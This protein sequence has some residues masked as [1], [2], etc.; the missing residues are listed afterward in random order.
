MSKSRILLVIGVGRSGTSAFVGIVRELGFYVPQPEVVA[1]DTNPRGFGEPRWV[2]DFHT[3]LLKKRAVTTIDSR[4]SAWETTATAATDD[5]VVA[6][7]RSWL[8]VQLVGADRIVVKDPRISWFLPLWRRCAEELGADTEFVTMLRPPTEVLASARQWYGT[9]QNDASRAGG[10]VNIMLRTERQSRGLPRAFV[11]YDDLLADWVAT[12]GRVG[13]LL[14]EP[15]LHDLDDSRRSRIDAFVSPELHRQIRGWED[16][17]VPTPLRG[18]VD[19]SWEALL[20]LAADGK[21][22]PTL[23]E[24]RREYEELHAESEAIAQSSIRAA[25]VGRKP[26]KPPK[27]APAPTPKGKAAP[28]PGFA[29]RV[30]RRLRRA[31]RGSRAH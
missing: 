14:D 8:E 24:L 18:L 2:V 20:A 21:Q 17:A 30:K 10:W 26:S 29:V 3:R 5:D 31:L 27:P 11:R 9:R 4:P 12:M 1:D 13:R 7:L 16:L 28:P 6:E 25:G 15:G 23:D 19:R 22:A